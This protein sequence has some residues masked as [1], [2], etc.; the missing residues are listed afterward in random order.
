MRAN[1]VG[2]GTQNK[3]ILLTALSGLVAG[4]C[5]MALGEWLSVTNARELARAQIAKEADEIEHTP[6]AERRE[7][8]LCIALSGVGLGAI[9]VF[10]SLFNGGSASFS[11]FRQ[12]VIGMVASTPGLRSYRQVAGRFAVI[13]YVRIDRM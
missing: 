13:D 3:A 5:S 10:T 1:G 6:D 8:A 9:G 11:A 2:V 7:L 4:A 12:I